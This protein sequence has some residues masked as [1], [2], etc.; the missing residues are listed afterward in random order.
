MVEWLKQLACSRNTVKGR[1]KHMAS[2]ISNQQKEDFHRCECFSICLNETTDVSP[3]ARIAE[4]GD[5]KKEELVT[6]LA[7]PEATKGRYIYKASSSNIV[8]T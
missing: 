2:D 5:R 8:R 4:S 1:V 3:E 6:L 7:V